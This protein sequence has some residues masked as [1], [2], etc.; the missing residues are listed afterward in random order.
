MKVDVYD[1]WASE[2]EVAREFGINLISEL[3][4][5]KYDA[6]ILAVDHSDFKSWGEAIIRKL[7]KENHIV[8]DL[9]YVLP[10]GSSDMRL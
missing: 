3:V 4:D 6:I 5:G 8:Y 9:K 10:L 2:G 1:H 7:G